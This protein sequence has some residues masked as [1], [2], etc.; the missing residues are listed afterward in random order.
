VLQVL[1]EELPAAER[2]LAALA[3]DYQTLQGVLKQVR[4]CAACCVCVRV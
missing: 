1:N 2:D 3:V 4:M